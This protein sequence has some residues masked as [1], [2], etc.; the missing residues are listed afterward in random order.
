MHFNNVGRV[1]L[2]I[3]YPAGYLVSFAGYPAGYLDVWPDEIKKFQN[4]FNI[5]K[6]RVKCL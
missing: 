3:R 6:I 5:Y 2:Y 4:I 1:V